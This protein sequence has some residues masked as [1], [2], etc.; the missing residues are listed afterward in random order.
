M[1]CATFWQAKITAQSTHISK[2]ENRTYYKYNHNNESNKSI[3]LKAIKITYLSNKTQT[4][5]NKKIL[6]LLHQ[7]RVKFQTQT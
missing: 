2:L 6:V 5:S 1:G 4:Y 7:L 3:I